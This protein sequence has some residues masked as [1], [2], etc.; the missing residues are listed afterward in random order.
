MH[1][2]AEQLIFFGGDDQSFQKKESRPI[3]WHQR[4]LFFFFFFKYCYA[5]KSSVYG[6]HWQS[7]FC[8][9]VV[10]FFS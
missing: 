9:E 2:L 3:W 5:L 7:N 10:R 1:L 8:K 6:F 4:R